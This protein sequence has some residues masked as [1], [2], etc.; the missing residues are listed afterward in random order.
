VDVNH[1]IKGAAMDETI[2]LM[3]MTERL[4]AVIMGG[5]SIYLGYRLFLDIPYRRNQEKGELELPGIKLVLSKVGPGIFFAAFGSLVLLQS[6]S[7]KITLNEIN[8]ASSQEVADQPSS[9]VKFVGAVN[10][11]ERDNSK[12]KLR[13]ITSIE[14]LNCINKI[15][16]ENT[17]KYA[18]Q[19]D[20]FNLALYQSKRVLLLSVWDEKAWG[21]SA[22]LSNY[23]LEDEANAQVKE[24]M[25]SGDCL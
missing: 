6:M 25:N 3:R 11:V 14:T 22:Q 1:L 15:L 12:E 8:Q 21:D 7:E 17:E 16:I 23:A 2:I 4:I 20:E 5:I 24:L 10:K 19:K 13:A 9:H 18:K